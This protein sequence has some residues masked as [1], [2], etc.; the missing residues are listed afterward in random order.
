MAGEIIAWTYFVLVMLTGHIVM[1]ALVTALLLKNFE[2]SLGNELQ[3]QYAVKDHRK[4]QLELSGADHDQK[5]QAPFCSA[6]AWRQRSE[7]ISDLFNQTF[8]GNRAALR[9]AKRAKE[10]ERAIYEQGPLG[11]GIQRLKSANLLSSL[12]YQGLA[13]G[14]S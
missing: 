5:L 13:L 1:M 12:V 2:Q 11:D 10:R 8:T 3:K 9:R 7:W 14:A 6:V 4:A